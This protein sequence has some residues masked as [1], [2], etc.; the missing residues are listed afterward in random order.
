MQDIISTLK[1][2]L[3]QAEAGLEVAVGRL[4]KDGT[5]RGDFKPSEVLALA[6]VREAL[7]MPMP[8]CLHQIQE[9]AA[10][11]QAA[12]HAGL[13]EGRAQA[14]GSVSNAT[15]QAAPAAVNPSETPNSSTIAVPS[16]W[17]LVPDDATPEWVENLEALPDWRDAVGECIKKFLAASPVAPQAA[18]AAVAVPGAVIAGALFDFCG[19]L[20]TLPHKHAITASEAHEASPMV[21]ALKQWAA[22]RNL[23]LDDADVQG[24][25]AALAATPAAAI[26][27]PISKQ[28]QQV[29]APVVPNGWVPCVVTYEGQHPEEV[30]YGPQVMM[31]R[32]KK[33]LGRYFELKAAAPVVLPPPDLW[34]DDEGLRGYAADPGRGPWY[35]ADT[36]RALLAQTAI[37]GLPVQADCERCGGSGEDPEGYYD[38]SR[39]PDGDTHDGPC[40]ECAGTGAAHQTPAADALDDSALLDA[41]ERQRIAVVPEYEGPWDA[42]VYNDDEKPN[43]HGT[44]ATPREAIRAAIAAAKGK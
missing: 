17:K 20:T 38:Q 29:T 19:Y 27:N 11:E 41:M 31:D 1:N 7:A 23:Q 34:R 44:G 40:R 30:A 43:H 36:L 37:A 14:T 10:A 42:E 39:G 18:P 21:E 25:S 32:L 5:E 28:N 2:A 6:S 3:L 24:W 22:K 9:P 8:L 26:G 33:W 13:D 16:G 35:T 15:S 4:T 12:W